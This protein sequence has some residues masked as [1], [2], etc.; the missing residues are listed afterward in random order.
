VSDAA[1]KTIAQIELIKLSQ[2]ASE[3]LASRLLNPPDERGHAPPF[4][5]SMIAK[6][7]LAASERLTDIS[8]GKPARICGGG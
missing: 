2:P 3:A 4:V 1:R 8:V 7:S 6:P 5:A